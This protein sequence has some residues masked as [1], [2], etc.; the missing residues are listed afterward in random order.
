M[1]VLNSLED[2]LELL[3]KRSGYYSSRPV[4]PM[5]EL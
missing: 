5:Y 1:I 3:E 2:A 4:I